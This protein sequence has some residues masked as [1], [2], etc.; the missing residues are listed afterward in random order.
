ML[1]PLLLLAAAAAASADVK[2]R[3]VTLET[4]GPPQIELPDAVKCIGVNP[5]KIAGNAER[6]VPGAGSMFQ[7]QLLKALLKRVPRFR[8]QDRSDIERLL[9]E[10][11]GGKLPAVQAVLVLRFGMLDFEAGGESG[12]KLKISAQ[13]R[14]L[15]TGT[16]ELAMTTAFATEVACDV[17]RAVDIRMIRIEAL[18]IGFR[19]L[20]EKVISRIEDTRRKEDV[21]LLEAG[22]LTGK[23]IEHCRAGDLDAARAKFQEAAASPG[24][25]NSGHYGLYVLLRFHGKGE[26]AEVHL[27]KAG[28]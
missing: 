5:P 23:A 6:S 14:L 12:E 13:V 17:K 7:S 21:I 22:P 3:R 19:R 10:N 25:R 18:R 15:L 28:E 11:P 2:V 24:E 16:G 26:A 1:V 4:G 8:Y 9:K 27:E 20:I